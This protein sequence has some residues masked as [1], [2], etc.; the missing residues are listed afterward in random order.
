MIKIEDVHEKYNTW[1][2]E[3]TFR[4]V[5][6]FYITRRY[7]QSNIICEQLIKDPDASYSIRW[8]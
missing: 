6:C 7:P 5:V 1:Y 2:W 3:D 8:K 4:T